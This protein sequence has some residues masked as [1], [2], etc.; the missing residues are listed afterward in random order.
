MKRDSLFYKLSYRFGSPHWDT[1]EPR[2]ELEEISAGRPPGRALD[3]GCGTGSNAVY[4][5]EQGWDVVG[6]DFVPSAIARAKERALAMGAHASFVAGDV[7]DLRQA[8]VLGA[9]DL[10]IDI[11]CYHTIPAHLRPA[12]EAE[13]AGVARSGAEFYLAG[14]S[15]PPASW[16]LLGA[17]GVDSTEL[18]ERFS[19]DFDLTDERPLGTIGRA[20][21]FVL[22]HMVRKPTRMLDPTNGSQGSS[23]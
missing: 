5:A 23:A 2:A 6:I 17:R 21:N 4:L 13:V 14:I 10:V 3:L 22:Y 19:A 12:Y 8:G 1:G 18:T 16:R 7:T 20:S 11:G 9:F 15:H